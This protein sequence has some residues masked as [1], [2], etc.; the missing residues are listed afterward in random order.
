MTVIDLPPAPVAV[1]S[2]TYSPGRH[3]RALLDSLPGASGAG[4]RVVLADNGSTDGAPQRAAAADARVSVLDTGGNVGYGAAI[5]AAAASLRCEVEERAVDPEFFLV[6]NPDVEL[7]P[8]AL[9]QLV[10]CARRNPRAGAVGPLIRD[11]NGAVYPSARAQPSLV[12]GA[13]HALLADMWPQN[14]FSRAYRRGSDMSCERSAGWLSGAC[15]LIRW[16]AF[17]EVG[18]FD[19]RYFM[20]LE[21]VDFGDRLQ[22]AGWQNVLCVDAEVVH[23]QG[24]AANA[25][26]VATSRAHHQSAY[27]FLAD[28]YPAWW[29]APVRAVVKAGLAVRQRVAGWA[30]SRQIA[31]GSPARR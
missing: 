8:G 5:N 23:D 6:V 19:E 3:L 7:G 14:P 17:D 27:A 24:H 1:I 18:G 9:D 22:R 2:V 13:G 20:Y 28:R 12:V 16:A 31:A 11:P 15:L 25:V 29:Q 4:C 21:D 10:A 30:A 26:P